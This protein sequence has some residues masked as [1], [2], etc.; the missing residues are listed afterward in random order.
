MPTQTNNH[1]AV[2]S[3]RASRLMHLG[4]LAV[5]MAGGMLA[6]GARRAWRGEL[7]DARSLLLTPDNAARLADKLSR[8]RGAAMKVGQL[9][10]MEA[11]ELLPPE[12]TNVLT[13]LRED[14]HYMPLGQ[15]AEQLEAEWGS[16][17]EQRFQRFSFT[18]LA[19]ASIGQ[20]HE[21]LLKDGR[22]LAVKLQ[23]PGVRRSID[24]DVDN[25]ATLFR[26]LPILPNEANL[27]P[28]FAEAKH[29]LHE[30]ADYRREATHLRHFR[31]LLKHD[32]DFLLPEIVDEF[33]SE[34][35]LAMS[36][37]SGS[38]VEALANADSTIRDHIVSM[39]IRLLFREFFE[40][41]TVQ[42]DPNFANY[43]YDAETNRIVLLDFGATRHYAPKRM[44]QLRNLMAAAYHQDQAA[45]VKAALPLGYLDDVDPP[46][47]RQSI[48]ELFLLICEPA[49]H[50]GAYD[51]G[52]S[53]LTTRLRDSSYAMSYDRGQ[54]R[55]PPADL[56]F[57]HRK[58]AGL[59][60]LAARLKA[61]VDVGALLIPHLN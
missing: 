45:V 27:A 44:A 55:P 24:S 2:P 17:W 33:S 5:G 13:R 46:A 58:L 42:T 12:F 25:V 61:R 3:H 40:F 29:Q 19:A 36:F 30:E 43:R 54:W 51:F 23:Y 21:A 35:V 49:R 56:I 10:S 4:G 41:G 6:E 57:L 32:P 14:A 60:L 28:L 47:R 53:D 59:F 20:V 18:P 31:D 39:L 1:A 26:L 15:V 34:N 9:L 8:M 50:A 7:T 37:V 16:G 48:I 22:R 38:P 52:N 11:G